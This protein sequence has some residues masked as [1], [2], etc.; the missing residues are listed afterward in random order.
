LFLSL[1]EAGLFIAGVKPVLLRDDPFVGFA[2]N[3]PLFVEQR[4]EQGRVF[5]DTAPNKLTFFNHQTFPK[6]KPPGTY[7]IFCLGGSTTY[8]RPYDDRVSFAGWLRELLPTADPSHRWEVINA[9]G[10]SYASYRVAM[11]ME[12]LARYEP[13]LFIIYSAHNEFLEQRSYGALQNAGNAVTG[14]A[15]RLARTRTWA[16]LS[17]IL[18]RSDILSRKQEVHRIVLP[19]EVDTILEKHGPDSYRRDDDNEAQ[20]ARHYRMSLERMVSTGTAAGADIIFITPASNLKDC[21]PFKSEHTVGLTEA[22]STRSRE[23]LSQA[24]ERVRNLEWADALATLDEA[25]AFDPRFADLHYSRGKALLGLERYDE[26]KAAFLSALKE[27]VC[28]LRVL[29]RMQESLMEVAEN[30]GLPLVDFTDL[31]EKRLQSEAD[32]SIPGEEYFLDHVHPSVEA[33]GLLAERL[34]EVMTEE[35]ILEPA[36]SWGDEAIAAVGETVQG[37]LDERMRA[38]GL[39]YL[40]QVLAWS[41]K[42]DEAMPLAVRALQIGEDYPVVVQTAASVLATQYVSKGDVD[43]AWKYF[44]RALHADPMSSDLHFRIGHWVAD[45]GNREI[46]VGFAHILHAS[47]FWSGPG[48]DRTH[49]QLGVTMAKRGRPAD[50]LAHFLEAQRLNPK[51]DEATGAA[52]QIRGET[53]S[54]LEQPVLQ[55]VS[56]EKYPSGVVSRIVQV[57]PNAAGRYVA[58]GFWTEWYEGGEVKRFVEY[59]NGAPYGAEMS[60]DQN[61]NRFETMESSSSE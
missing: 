46:E 5:L 14:A 43:Q 2:S 29:P 36:E 28:K 39:A 3:V 12:E 9:G 23:L 16:A 53:D 51:N 19:G 48:R 6:E 60:W 22:Q 35:G 17:W 61:G 33:H 25:L 32:H 40:A 18:E 8:G 27:D 13:D 21:S 58:D 54:R 31:I 59:R 30:A 41:G 38:E 1:F 44:R 37:R 49:L 42:G 57:K 34:I 20:V 10:I 24:R 55:K 52:R 56:V 26:A 50:A 45:T 15:S 11:L 47:V 4:D 7:R